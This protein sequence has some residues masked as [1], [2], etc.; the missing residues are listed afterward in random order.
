MVY[1]RARLI[2]LLSA[3]VCVV[4]AGAA[5]AT[6]GRAT[7]LKVGNRLCNGQAIAPATGGGVLLRVCGRWSNAIARISP[8]GSVTRL[9]EV[10]SEG[11]PVLEGP[12]GEVWAAGNAE[13]AARADRIAP[14]GKV[15][16]FDLANWRSGEVRVRGLVSTP[17]GSVWVALAKEAFAPYGM[18]YSTLGGELV[19]I[20]R[21]GKVRHFR[22]PKGIAVQGL[23]L[24]PDGNLWFTG[25]AGR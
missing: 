22:V 11:G 7:A 17:D 15:R 8:D 12:R 10:R 23:A 24:G 13:G 2:P 25:I 21:K 16:Q 6:P 1:A 20:S 19:R 4:A 5:L 14:D 18:V 3:V 9:G